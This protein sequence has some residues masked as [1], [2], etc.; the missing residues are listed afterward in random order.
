MLAFLCEIQQHGHFWKPPH[1][2]IEFLQI[3]CF[4]YQFASP[5]ATNSAGHS[6]WQVQESSNLA[7]ILRRFA[8][9]CI[10]RK[11][12]HLKKLHHFEINTTKRN[13]W[14]TLCYFGNE[15]TRLEASNGWC[16]CLSL[17]HIWCCSIYL[18]IRIYLYIYL[19]LFLLLNT[20][21]LVSISPSPVKAPP[22][23][24]LLIEGFVMRVPIYSDWLSYI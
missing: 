12:R 16:R 9:C 21:L 6:F 15:T 14:K 19:T 23:S 5:V 24:Q 2:S 13:T 22:K 1:A 20:A 17:Q 7:L 11:C 3:G 4:S 18:Y 8:L 10:N